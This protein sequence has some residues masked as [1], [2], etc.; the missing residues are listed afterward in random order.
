VTAPAHSLQGWT[1]IA[2]KWVDRRPLIR[3]CFTEGIEFTDP[4]FDQ[5]IDRCLLDPF[6][7]LFWR[8]SDIGSL[9]ELAGA[10]PGLEP[11]GFIFHVSRCGSTLLTQMLARLTTSL[12]MSEPGPIDG[13]LRAQMSQPGITDGEVVDWLRWMVSALGQR[14]RGAQAHFVIK[15]DA[16]A[17]LFF[18]LIRTA[19]P[20]TA[21][22]FVYRDPVEVVVS[23][24]GHRGYHMIP[25]TLPPAWFGLSPQQAYSVSA[26]GYCAAVLAALCNSALHLAREGHLTLIQYSTLPEAVPDSVAA[27]FGIDVGPSERA[28][29][30][31]VAQR[32]A[33]NPAVPFVAD[34]LDK[35]RRATS[36]VRAA[37]EAQVGPVY[38]S[39]ETLRL[40]R[41]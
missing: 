2:V 1:P 15:L 30:A 40:D 33:K 21:C 28:V 7:L 37:V 26:E 25:G 4:F 9:G 27:L 29:L 32:N 3:W 22:V 35:R 23:H 16:W 19:F 39:L 34:A 6:R 13:V 11:A 12:V 24:L 10:S 5:T 31:G 17:I 18:R 36:E 41:S 8:E 14:R 38:E 20:D